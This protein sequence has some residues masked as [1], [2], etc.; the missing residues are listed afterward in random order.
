MVEVRRQRWTGPWGLMVSQP[1]LLGAFWAN[2]TVFQD[3]IDR[4]TEYSA[5]KDPSCKA[6]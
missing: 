5:G 6:G 1:S 2:E 3:K 4:A